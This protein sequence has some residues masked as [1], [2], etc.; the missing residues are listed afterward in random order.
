MV[1]RINKG[2]N[3]KLDYDCN[4][5]T[6]AEEAARRGAAPH[7]ITSFKE[8]TKTMEFYKMVATFV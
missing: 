7:M 5:D 2:K 3:N 6:V 8:G 4:P 1:Y